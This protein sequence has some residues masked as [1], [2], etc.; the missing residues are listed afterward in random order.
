[1]TRSRYDEPTPA[2]P[3]AFEPDGPGE[4]GAGPHRARPGVA[5]GSAEWDAR[6]AGSDLVW[7]AGANRYVVEHTD[8]LAPGR[9]VD[10]ACGEGRNAVHLAVRGWRVTGVDFSPV[11]IS[12]ARELERAR[13]PGPGATPVRWV[14]ADVATYRPDPVDLAVLAYLHLAPDARRAV[15]TNAVSAL[16]PGARILVIGHNTRNI[17]EG[18]GGPQDPLLLYT[19]AD[20]VADLAAIDPGLRAE[21]AQEP[22]RPVPGAD[23]PAIDTVVLARR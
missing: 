17:A 22:L 6:Y 15:L 11:A 10:L 18:T 7:G 4:P 23:R 1:M 12:K 2:R 8:A 14:C 9:A 13:T 5:M 21:I 19:A 3:G 16:A 20:V